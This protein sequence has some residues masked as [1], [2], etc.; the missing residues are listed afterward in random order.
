MFDPVAN[1]TKSLRRL[2]FFGL[3]L[4]LAV[5]TAGVMAASAG[6]IGA[7]SAGTGVKADRLQS[8]VAVECDRDC[9]ASLGTLTQI[10]HDPAESLTTATR[11]PSN[12]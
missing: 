1:R 5:A 3:A 4:A 8:Q 6:A 10:I 12:G 9:T 7:S 2:P 11:G